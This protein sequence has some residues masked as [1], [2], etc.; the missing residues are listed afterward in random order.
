MEPQNG[1][2]EMLNRAATVTLISGYLRDGGGN[3]RPISGP[4]LQGNNRSVH[5]P[6]ACA[7]SF[8]ENK[9]HNIGLDRGK[10]NPLMRVVV[11]DVA[12]GG[13]ST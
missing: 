7:S 11:S 6:A 9:M 2:A 3:P 5:L 10:F 4:V 13:A 8:V 12:K 1:G